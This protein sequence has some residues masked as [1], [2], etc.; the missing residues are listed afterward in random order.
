MRRHN[1]PIANQAGDLI[2]TAV[3]PDSQPPNSPATVFVGITARIDVTLTNNTGADITLQSGSQASVLQIFLPLFYTSAEVL[4]MTVN[5]ADWRLDADP[6]GQFLSLTYTGPDAARWPN[7]SN[8]VFTIENATSTG[9]PTGDSLQI[10]PSNLRGDVPAQVQT[11]LNLANPPQPGNAKL[12]DTLQ[13]TLDNQGSV[14][15]SSSVTDP[16]TNRIFLNLKNTGFTPVYNGVEPWTGRPQVIVTFIY[17][18][19][20]G[21]LAPDDNRDEP[22]VGSAWSIRSTVTVNPDGGWQVIN[23]QVP[24]T[25]P[26]PKWILQ[27]TST[28]L[29]IIGTGANANVTFAF[30]NIISLTPPG[31]TQMIVEFTGFRKDDTTAYNDQVFVLDIVKQIAPPTRGLINFFAPEAL[32]QLTKPG[33][34]ISI[35]LRWAMFDVDSISLVSTVAGMPPLLRTY[36]NPQPVAYDNEP[37]ELIGPAQSTPVFFT[38]QAFDGNGGYLNSMQFTVF[39]QTEFFYDPRDGQT[40]PVVLVGKVWW[41]ARNLDYAASG[42]Y[43]YNNNPGYDQQFGRMYPAHGSGSVPSPWRIPTQADWK[44]LASQLS[45]AALIEGGFNAQLGGFGQQSS[46][47]QWSGMNSY[48]YYWTSTPGDDSKTVCAIFSSPSQQVSVSSALLDSWFASVRYVRN[49]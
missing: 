17:G 19:T 37:V 36:V 35:P 10:N 48:G 23:P 32:V 34:S 38:L 7:G 12:S 39:L 3:N 30:T 47:I 14:Y 24:Y 16:L 6:S 49:A 45:Y 27:P 2:L 22:P 44:A 28:N 9:S 25:D 31:H 40:Y 4:A 46:G 18:V 8:L 29:G 42:S 43:Y 26:S 33:G 1:L 41:M 5:R 11:P 15:V 21:A 20:S 13:I